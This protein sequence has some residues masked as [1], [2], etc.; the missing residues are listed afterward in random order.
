MA[1]GHLAGYQRI[2]A[3]GVNL[4]QGSN[5]VHLS[6]YL[7]GGGVIRRVGVVSEASQGLLAPSVLAVRYS[8]DGG[9]NFTEL[10]TLTPGA[11]SRGVPV[12][13]NFA[14]SAAKLSPGT[15]VQLVDKTAGGG[16]STGRVWL[17]VERE[18]FNGASIPSTAVAK[19]A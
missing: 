8:T 18:V 9:A 16:T 15:L 14:T 17:D 13:R 10:G 6:T 3:S 7:D 5:A 19:T 2:E 4:N 11:Q 12:Y 1:L